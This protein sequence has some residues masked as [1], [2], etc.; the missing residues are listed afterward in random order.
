MEGWGIYPSRIVKRVSFQSGAKRWEWELP[1]PAGALERHSLERALLERAI[2]LGTEVQMGRSIERWEPCEGGFSLFLSNGER[3]RTRVLF[4]GIGRMAGAQQLSPRFVGYQGHLEGEATGEELE[5]FLLPG[6]Y[7][8][9]VSVAEGKENVAGLQGVGA[10]GVPAP[11]KQVLP[12]LL[13]SQEPLEGEWHFVVGGAF[14]M[15]KR[16]IQKNFYAIG[17]A[18][19]TIPPI[20]GSGTGL[21]LYSGIYA[22]ICALKE[23]WE[24]YDPTWRREVAQ[25]I[26]WGCWLHGLALWNLSHLFVRLPQL[27]PQLAS[28]F[29]KKTRPPLP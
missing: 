24:E 10:G 17:D 7:F 21:A 23:A 9:R 5:M 3:V 15:R 16:V 6:G 28:F 2:S 4:S 25:R 20:T 13:S 29:W 12:S 22:G 27:V 19:A 18:A 14:G 11:T 26:K 1:T 8:G